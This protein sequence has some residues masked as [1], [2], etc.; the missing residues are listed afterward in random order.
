[1]NEHQLVKVLNDVIAPCV[2]ENL[3]IRS[4]PWRKC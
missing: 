2:K 1:M 4:R 3:P